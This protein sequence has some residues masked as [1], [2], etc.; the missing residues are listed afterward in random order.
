MKF[1]RLSVL[2]ILTIIPAIMAQNDSTQARFKIEQYKGKDILVGQ[3]T[4]QDIWENISDW[5]QAYDEFQPDSAVVRKFRAIS[6][7][8]TIVCVFGTWCPD[9][10]AGVPEF[11][12]TLKAADNPHLKLELFAVDRQKNDPDHSAAK[13][14]IERIPTFVVFREGKEIGRMVETPLRSFEEDFLQLIQE[15]KMQQN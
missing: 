6:D 11:I 9:S 14:D 10:K 12:K 4:P 1:F 8:Y 7:D 3:V 15:A 2:L 13:Y 5:K